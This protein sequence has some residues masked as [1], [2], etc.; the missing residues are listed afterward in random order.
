[1]FNQ[2]FDEPFEFAWTDDVV[3]SALVTLGGL[4]GF[5]FGLLG[6]SCVA[7][8]VLCLTIVALELESWVTGP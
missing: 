2:D 1:M 6:V 3:L 4:G 8:I 7:C 5:R